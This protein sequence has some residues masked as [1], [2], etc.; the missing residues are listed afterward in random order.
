MYMV[1]M[2]ESGKNDSG[3]SDPEQPFHIHTGLLVHE[4]QYISMSGEY[5]ALFRRHFGARPRSPGVPDQLQTD[6]IYNG[7]GLFESWE[8]EQRAE[9]L[10]DCFNILIRRETPILVSYID[11]AEFES[12]SQSE[13]NSLFGHD[14]PSRLAF[15]RFLMALTMFLDENVMQEMDPDEIM[16]ST[17]SIR[18]YA[19]LMPNADSGSIRQG[20]AEFLSDESDTVTPSMYDDLL[21]APPDNSVGGLLVSMCAYFVKRW[22]QEPNAPHSYFE[23]LRDGR[24]IQV[25]Y[26]YQFD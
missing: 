7:T 10:Q 18:D 15:G 14:D 3:V 21:I 11:K 5:E 19:M 12:A 6:A 26:P 16:Q 20:M 22:V 17:W 24:V 2:N 13:S 25:I 8:P 9:L 1:F 4:N 23:G